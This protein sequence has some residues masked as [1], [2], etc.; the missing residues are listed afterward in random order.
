[1]Y[2]SP[3]AR[4]SVDDHPLTLHGAVYPHGIGTHALSQL[5]VDLKGVAARFMALVGVD[6]EANSPGTVTFQV[7]VDRKRV[8]ETRV[9]HHGDPPQLLSVDL[10]G[11]RRMTLIVSDA[12]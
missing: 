11:A 1:E 8:A 3:R 9:L 4:R 12:G 5:T 7:W 2:G 6:D 10:T